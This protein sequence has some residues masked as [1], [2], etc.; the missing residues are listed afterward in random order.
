MILVRWWMLGKLSMAALGVSEAGNA[1]GSARADAGRWWPEEK[2]SQVP[3]VSVQLFPPRPAPTAVPGEMPEI[4]VL[5]PATRTA[6]GCSSRPACQA[7]CRPTPPA[8][9]HE[10]NSPAS[11]VAP[12]ASPGSAATPQTVR[13]PAAGAPGKPTPSPG[14]EVLPH[15]QCGATPR[16]GIAGLPASSRSGTAPAR[17]RSAPPLPPATPAFARLSAHSSP[18]PRSPHRAGRRRPRAQCSGDPTVGDRQATVFLLV[19]S[20]ARML[21]CNEPRGIC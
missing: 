9:T 1:C 21:A 10:T 8:A 15:R 20:D 5:T 19:P 17:S 18:R 16:P 3:G 2:C 13:S 4:P 12:K 7:C 14:C 11:R 6:T